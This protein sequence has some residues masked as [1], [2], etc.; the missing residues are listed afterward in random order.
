MRSQDHALHYSASRG[1]N[2]AY[3]VTHHSVLFIY[4]TLSFPL[5]LASTSRNWPRPHS[6]GL[7][8][9]L[10][11]GL[12]ALASA[13]ASRFWPRLTSLPLSSLTLTFDVDF[14]RQAS[15]VIVSSSNSRSVGSKDKTNGRT[16]A[17][18]L[19]S[20][21]ITRS[22]IINMTKSALCRLLTNDYTLT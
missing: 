15:W 19:H 3:V 22:V 20:G 2:S 21:P 4:L 5:V 11:L 13:S 18:A 7:G 16:L 6:P 17:I 8:L 9:G 10:G 1:K 14:Q 12:V